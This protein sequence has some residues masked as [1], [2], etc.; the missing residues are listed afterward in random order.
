MKRTYTSYRRSSSRNQE[1]ILL[2]FVSLLIVA[3]L[4]LCYLALARDFEEVSAKL[5]AGTLLNLNALSHADSLAPFLVSFSG[6]ADR[7]FV[8]QK[9]VATLSN[10][11]GKRPKR[12]QNVGQL[13]TLRATEEEILQAQGLAAIRKKVLLTQGREERDTLHLA[14]SRVLSEPF[15]VRGRI[16]TPQSKPIAGVSVVFSGDSSGMGRTDRTG[17]FQIMGLKSGKR[18]VLHP[19]K[20]GYTFASSDS[21]ARYVTLS[22][23]QRIDF[24]GEPLTPL[25]TGSLAQIKPN[26]V[27]RTPSEFR[28]RYWVYM[29]GLYLFG[30]YSVHLL[31][32]NGCRLRWKK[33]W[34]WFGLHKGAPFKGDQLML[35]IIHLISGIGL[36]AMVSLRDPLRDHMIGLDFAVGYL[37]GTVLLFLVSGLD[38]QRLFQPVKWQR[39]FIRPVIGVSLLGSLALSVLLIGWGSGPTGSQA[40]VNL[41]FF[42]PA[43]FISLLLIFYMAAYFARH[44]ELL[45]GLQAGSKWKSL[46]Q[47]DLPRLRYFLPIVVTIAGAL[48]LYWFQQDFGPALLLVFT[49]LSLYYLARKRRGLIH[50]ALVALFL[51][52]AIS[53]HFDVISTLSDRVEM[54]VAQWDNFVIGGSQ[55]A[56]AYWALSTGHVYGTGAGL[57]WPGYIPAGFTDMI[58]AVVGE[59]FGWIGVVM[60]LMLYAILLSRALQIAQGSE[61]RFGF[62]LGVGLVL[63]LGYQILL[64]SGGM[65]GLLPLSGVVTPFLSYGKSAMIVNAIMVGIWM[66]LSEHATPLIAQPEM[67][68]PLEQLKRVLVT[69][70]GA[71]VLMSGYIQLIQAD[72]YLTKPALVQFKHGNRDYVY[73]PRLLV[74]RRELRMGSVYDRNGIPLATSRSEELEASRAVY[75][76]LGGGE[77]I[78]SSG[79]RQYPFG[80]LTFY[81]L[82]DLNTRLKWGASNLYNAERRHLSELRGFDNHPKIASVIVKKVAH[83]LVVDGDTTMMEA[84]HYEPRIQYDYQALIPLIRHG[85]RW[86]SMGRVKA[87]RQGVRDIYLSIDIRL[88]YAI[89]QIL[90]AQTPRGK[91]AAAVVTDAQTG[92]V[93]AAVNYPWPSLEDL[94]T[95]QLASDPA[96]F[97]RAGFGTYPPG[98]TFKL[99]TAMASLRKDAGNQMVRHHC[100]SLSHG[101]VGN[102]VG[103][104]LVRD[105]PGDPAHGYPSLRRALVVSCNAYF[106]QLGYH[107]TG[108]QKLLETLNLFGMKVGLFAEHRTSLQ[109]LDTTIGQVSF[110]Q[111][112]LVA[113]PLQMA[114]VAATV[115]NQ[116]RFLPA[117]WIKDQFIEPIEVVSGEQAKYLARAMREVVTRGTAQRVARIKPQ[118]AGKTGT[119]DNSFGRPHAWFIGYAPYRGTRS[120]AFAVLVENGG[121]GGRIAAPIAGSIVQAANELGL[122]E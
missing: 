19:Q 55:V 6:E 112:S 49:F 26:L 57:G 95:Q 84:K 122:L 53:Y 93:L 96:V 2:L 10:A 91:R 47:W 100:R 14:P 102:R 34:P 5:K 35:P 52:L 24:I 120:I 23:T 86:P 78:A 29:V 88:Q 69:G 16:T 39:Y 18:Y 7:A 31:W 106:A 110:G 42:Q 80:P 51:G 43:P 65:L 48:V 20:R 79:K 77:T 9:V 81:L 21:T 8:A 71:I 111:G 32:R 92:E 46:R 11:G 13:T 90:Q 105:F 58:L 83:P 36:I 66:S 38:L 98:S 64:I 104:R 89:A 87:L 1:L 44:G 17:W 67:K 28:F 30:A 74:A 103:R 3:G 61:T 41:W 117:T 121:S 22:D 75:Q 76:E 109:A 4:G 72:T 40:K 25:L 37:L 108:A 116:G 63:F 56:E 101:R 118:I 85:T 107:N 114:T 62:F 97:D 82:G 99:V 45:E 115:A 119:A 94:N 15:V 73:N 27:V 60:V 113:S 12:F 59:D 33:N 70:L 54:M 68:Q 50:F